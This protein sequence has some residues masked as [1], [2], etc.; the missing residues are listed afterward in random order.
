ME[1]RDGRNWKWER[2]INRLSV[3][4]RQYS[5]WRAAGNPE[6]CRVMRMFAPLVAVHAKSS[7]D[8]G[9]QCA[10]ILLAWRRRTPVQRIL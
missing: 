3:R 8:S 5:T 4:L 7:T 1:W 9:E 10:D 2:A 6:G